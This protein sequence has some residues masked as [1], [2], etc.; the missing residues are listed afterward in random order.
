MTNKK[1]KQKQ[2]P[3]SQP[4]KKHEAQSHYQKEGEQFHKKVE[5][6][7]SEQQ[8]KVRQAPYSHQTKVKK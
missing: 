5:K 2:E 4:E 7:E 6:F 8:K 1:V 3:Q